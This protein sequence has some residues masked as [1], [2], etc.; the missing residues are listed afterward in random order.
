[1]FDII[2]YDARNGGTG[3]AKG[4]AIAPQLVILGG[5]SLVYLNMCGYMY[6]IKTHNS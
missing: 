6:V 4:G 5:I 2:I 3:I 1:M